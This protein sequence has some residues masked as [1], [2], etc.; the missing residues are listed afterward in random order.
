MGILTE[1]NTW[2]RRIFQELLGYVEPSIVRGRLAA[3]F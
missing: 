1:S 2:D 3:T